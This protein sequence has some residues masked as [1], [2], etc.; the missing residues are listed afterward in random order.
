MNKNLYIGKTVI[1]GISYYDENDSFLDQKQFHGKIVDADP[2]QG[3]RC[4]DETKNELH[5]LPPRVDALFPA[6]PGIYREYSTGEIIENPDFI[7][8]WNVK[9]QTGADDKWEWVSHKSDLRIREQ[10]E[11]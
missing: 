2:E 1:V 5:V 6:P 10:T 4:V 8:L 9:K 3:I 7:S 11:A